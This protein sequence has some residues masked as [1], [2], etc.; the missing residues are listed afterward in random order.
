MLQLSLIDKY[1]P[2]ELLMNEICK[3]KQE[4]YANKKKKTMNAGH[5]GHGY[6]A[7]GAGLLL[8]FEQMRKHEEKTKEDDDD[9]A[10]PV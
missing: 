6:C 7:W 10:S 2:R 3:C 4:E 5:N 1:T 9:V 8:K